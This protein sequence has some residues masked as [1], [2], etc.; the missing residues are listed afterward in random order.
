[1][2]SDESN[3]PKEHHKCGH[4]I[5]VLHRTLLVKKKKHVDLSFTW[6]CLNAVMGL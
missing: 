5:D 2:I 6:W 1:M 4:F 3:P